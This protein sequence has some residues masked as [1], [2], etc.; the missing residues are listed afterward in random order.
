[1]QNDKYYRQFGAVNPQ[2]IWGSYSI[3]LDRMGAAA[4]ALEGEMAWLQT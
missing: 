3:D 1:M 4:E 2:K